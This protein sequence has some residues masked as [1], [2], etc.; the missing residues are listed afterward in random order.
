M[1][2]LKT[3]GQ[4]TLQEVFDQVASHLLKQN[5]RCN[6]G[7]VCAYRNSLGMSC[8]AGCLI[9]DDEYT[10][11]L[12]GLEWNVLVKEKMVPG[13]HAGAIK[14]LQNIH[15]YKTP[16]YWREALEGFAKGANLEFRIQ[17]YI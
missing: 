17:D 7:S 3:L 16:D 5:L 2:T 13:D 12:E 14:A 10:G 15:D 11:Q 1:I 6:E 9:G 4:A 8:A